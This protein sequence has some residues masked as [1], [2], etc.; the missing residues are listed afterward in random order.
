M[1]SASEF[2]GAPMYAGSAGGADMSAPSNAMTW[3]A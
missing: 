3:P 1:R 2:M